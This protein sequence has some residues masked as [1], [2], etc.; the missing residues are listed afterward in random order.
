MGKT[1]KEDNAEGVVYDRSSESVQ[2][3]VMDKKEVV[4][5]YSFNSF[6]EAYEAA[7]RMMGDR[8]RSNTFHKNYNNKRMF[9][10]SSLPKMFK[11]AMTMT[12]LKPKGRVRFYSDGVAGFAMNEAEYKMETHLERLFFSATQAE[13]RDM[14]VKAKVE[15]TKWKED[16]QGKVITES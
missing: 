16:M 12:N 1:K 13:S 9:L 7:L 5:K 2:I 3:A 15:V 14:T 8:D 10:A 11:S 6:D 4:D